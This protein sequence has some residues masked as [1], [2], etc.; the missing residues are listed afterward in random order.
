MYSYEKLIAENKLTISELPSDAQT[1]IRQIQDFE[2][3]AGLQVQRFAKQGK[4]YKLPASTM[5]KI[6]TTDKWVVRE[7]LDYLDEK[8][9]AAAPVVAAPSAEDAEKMAEMYRSRRA[10]RKA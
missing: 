8:E 4:E 6:R 3:A 1:G 7:I 2:K 5:E 9:A 10:R